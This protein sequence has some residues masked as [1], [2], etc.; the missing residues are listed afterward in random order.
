MKILIIGY[1]L[2]HYLTVATIA[3]TDAPCSGC[4]VVYSDQGVFESVYYLK[5]N[6]QVVLVDTVV[7]AAA[8]VT[9]ENVHDAMIAAD[10]M[11]RSR[12]Q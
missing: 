12:K 3:S 8:P 9:P 2:I 10:A 1:F 5:M 11:G 4:A 7:I 6:P